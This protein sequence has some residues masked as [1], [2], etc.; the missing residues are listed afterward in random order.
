MVFVVRD[1]EQLSRP[2]AEQKVIKARDYW[3]FKEAQDA[4]AEAMRK[5]D[6]IVGAARTAYESERRRG[7]QEGLEAAKLE[8]SSNM[9]QLVG[10]SVD[11]FTKVEAR[12]VELVFE[13][14]R[15]VVHRFDDREHIVT[16]VRN[17]LAAVRT[18][19]HLT[20]RVHP[21]QAESVRAK[22]GE[23]QAAYPAIECIDVAADAR[24]AHDACAVESEIGVVEASVSGQLQALRDTFGKVFG[25][26]GFIHT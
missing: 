11:Y 20:V 19:R 13:A 7:Y 21:D 5:H 8:Q 12:M 23:L 2:D 6:E 10:R 9:M 26:A 3:A 4:V 18:Q 16:V 15:S 22:V 14:V 1:T 25:H 24:L 17:A